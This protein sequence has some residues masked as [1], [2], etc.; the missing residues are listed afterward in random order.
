MLKASCIDLLIK[1]LYNT[2][3]GALHGGA[4]L[5]GAPRARWYGPPMKG[6]TT[7]EK[8]KYNPKNGWKP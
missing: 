1:Q 7:W 3:Y 2:Q 4:G 5:A 8:S 6:V